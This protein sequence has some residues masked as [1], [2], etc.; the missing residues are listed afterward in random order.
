MLVVYVIPRARPSAA[1]AARL[2]CSL[3]LQPGTVVGSLEVK[4]ASFRE[5]ARGRAPKDFNVFRRTPLVRLKV[6]SRGSIPLRGK[7]QHGH[8]RRAEVTTTE[9]GSAHKKVPGGQNVDSYKRLAEVFHQVLSEQSLGVLLDT[10]ADTISELVPYDT[11]TI[12]EANETEGTLRPVLARDQWSEQIMNSMSRFGEGLTG[13]AAAHREPLLVNQAQLDPRTEVIPGTA[14]D[15]ESLLVIPLIARNSVKGCLNIYRVGEAAVFTKGEFELAKRFGDAAALALD[16]AETKAILELQAQTDSLTGLY[17]HRFFQE[18]LRAELGRAN[19]GHDSTA[20]LMFDIDNFKKVNDVYGHAVGDQVLQGV[21]SLLRSTIRVSD[22]VCRIGGEEFAVIMPSC[23]AGDATGFATRLRE[24]L[25]ELD[26]DPV[27][28]M[29]VSVGI[30][31]AP[32]HAMNPTE[33]VACSEAAMMTAKARGKDLVVLF[34]DAQTER[35]ED[36]SEHR[37]LRSLAHMKMLQSLGS[38]LNRLNDIREIALTI[39]NELRSLIDYHSC[40]VYIVEGQRLI[41]IAVRGDSPKAGDTPKTP[42]TKVGEGMVGRVAETGHSLLIPN[43]IECDFSI[44]IPGTEE[45]DESMM[46]VPLA[47]GSR[48]IGV[49]MLSKLGLDQFDQDDIRVLEVLAGQAS[50]AVENARLYE[51]QRR[52]TEKAKELLQFADAMTGTSSPYGIAETAV[53]LIANLLDAP[54]VSLWLQKEPLGGISCAAYHGYGGRGEAR[55]LMASQVPLKIATSFIG[56]HRAPFV[57]HPSIDDRSTLALLAEGSTPAIAPLQ[58][59]EGLLGWIAVV[60]PPGE[61]DYFTE[62]SLRFLDGLSHQTSVALQKAR[63]YQGQKASAEVSNALLDFSGGLVAAVGLEQVLEQTVRLAGRI[64]GSPRTSLWMRDAESGN[65]MA[66]AAWGHQTTERTQLEGIAIPRQLDSDIASSKKPFVIGRKQAAQY[67]DLLESST[68]LSFA[69]API[70]LEGG[71]NAALV[72]GAP[73]YGDYEFSERKMRLLAGIANQAKLAMDSAMSSDNLERNFVSTLEALTNT[74]EAKELSTLAPVQSITDMAIAV[75][76]EIGLDDPALTRLELGA[77]FH[78]IGKIGIRADI[79]MKAGRLTDEERETMETH[80]E[81]GERILAPIERLRDVR[82]VVRH[83]HERW[84]GGGY[85]DQL[86]AE[87]IPI[88]ARIVFV[89]D[90]F[91]AM[92][93]DRVYRKRFPLSEALR[94][95]EAGAGSQFDPAI[96][97]VFLRLMGSPPTPNGLAS[98]K[99]GSAE[100]ATFDS[101]RAPSIQ[102]SSN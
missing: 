94:R 60:E 42:S 9:S 79:L 13:Y 5:P 80:P 46:G 63:L 89:C 64:L 69:V 84:D 87:E 25:T 75:G 19:R 57:F 76:N 22:V 35:P 77:L 23:D 43:A 70:Q 48:V 3:P 92:V 2:L 96:I 74:L 17:N 24:K 71:D 93:T 27:G 45:I 33:L 86:A 14:N 85:P 29:T 101:R 68:N 4:E 50:V 51:A 39:T 1:K 98:Q 90:A 54:Q 95:L 58:P 18:R 15:P 59:S 56:Q 41:P 100:T 99:P 44:K 53:R 30:A 47:Y 61:E 31:Q 34:E 65:M 88:E 62:E 81:L 26:F 49:V 36:A 12:Y 6:A 11:L 38:K 78:D 72:A 82:H 52:E 16:N 67:G 37:D 83:C 8:D 97:E 91:H 40:R 32:E 102:P 28:R 20:L 66:R 73:A 55:K 10:I 21:G 7:S